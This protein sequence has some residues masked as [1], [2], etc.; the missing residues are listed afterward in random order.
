MSRG[1][2]LLLSAIAIIVAGCTSQTSSPETRFAAWLDRGHHQQVDAYQAFLRRRNVADILPS[3]Q[4]LRSGRRWQAC[5]HDEFVVPPRES[6]Q[7]MVP[8]LQLLAKLKAQG[9][10]LNAVSASGY[11]DAEFNRCEGGSSRSKHLLNS[12]LD[13]DAVTPTEQLALCA[14][15]KKEGARHAFGLGFYSGN[16]IHIDTAGYRTWGQDYSHRS[17]LCRGS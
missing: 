1:Q 4:L 15:W 2:P 16:R 3:H 5:S 7:E 17:S 14:W 6:W 10:R 13:L 9:V 8:T 12:A 11:R